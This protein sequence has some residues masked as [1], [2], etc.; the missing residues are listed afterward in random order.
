M[1][2]LFLTTG[3]LG[4]YPTFS[5]SSLDAALFWERGQV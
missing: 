2:R 5:A 1:L 3:I 4:G